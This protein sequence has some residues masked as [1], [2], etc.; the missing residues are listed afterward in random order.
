M[1]S[2]LQ[3]VTTITVNYNKFRTITTKSQTIT[4]NLQTITT[5]IVRTLII[6]VLTLTKIS[7]HNEIYTNHIPI[8]FYIYHL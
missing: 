6:E 5:I 3:T 7:T 4:K 1:P 8:Q 2:L